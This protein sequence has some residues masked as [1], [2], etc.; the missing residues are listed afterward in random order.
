MIVPSCHNVSQDF[1][2]EEVVVE[3]E[4]ETKRAKEVPSSSR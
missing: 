4:E 1:I 2:E 3:E